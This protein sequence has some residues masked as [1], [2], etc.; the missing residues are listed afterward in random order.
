MALVVIGRKATL[1]EAVLFAL[2]GKS[3]GIQLLPD[4]E[5]CSPE[6]LRKSMLLLEVQINMRSVSDD[7]VAWCAPR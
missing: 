7:E 5:Y 4:N 2:G 1:Q 3:A 6:H